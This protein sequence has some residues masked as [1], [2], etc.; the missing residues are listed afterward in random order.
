MGVF[1]ARLGQVEGDD[2]AHGAA[3]HV[4]AR[5]AQERGEYR[6]DHICHVQYLHAGVFGPMTTHLPQYKAGYCEPQCIHIVSSA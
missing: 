6:H 1:E 4:E 5:T 3:V 2:V